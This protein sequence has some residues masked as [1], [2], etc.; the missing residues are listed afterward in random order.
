MKAV[1]LLFLVLLLLSCS[2][3]ATASVSSFWKDSSEITYLTEFTQTSYTIGGRTWQEQNVS[4]FETHVTI[5]LLS[6]TADTSVMGLEYDSS[7]DSSFTSNLYPYA[8]SQLNINTVTGNDNDGGYVGVYLD[9]SK[10]ENVQPRTDDNGTVTLGIV[11]DFQVNYIVEKIPISV[12]SFVSDGNSGSLNLKYREGETYK[13][14]FYTLSASTSVTH[15]LTQIEISD[16]LI[17]SQKGGVLLKR[18]LVTTTQY[19]TTVLQSKLSLEAVEVKDLNI[20]TFLNRL[21][22]SYGGYVFGFVIALQF[23]NTRK[24]RKNE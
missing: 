4:S 7:P 5:R 13:V 9:T 20:Q 18:N 1:P 10:I 14:D 6:L 3:P 23:V 11:E 12:G 8:A 15:N 19:N 24:S 21:D 16:D 17:V 2:H 22:F